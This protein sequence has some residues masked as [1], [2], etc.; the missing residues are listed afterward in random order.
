MTRFVIV[1]FWSGSRAFTLS[2]NRT[3]ITGLAGRIPSVRWRIHGGAVR[4]RSRIAW[5]PKQ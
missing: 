2:K 3:S 4:V 5:A 1:I